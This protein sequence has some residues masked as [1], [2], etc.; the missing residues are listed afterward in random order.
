MVQKAKA[1]GRALA[2]EE[3][4]SIRTSKS[5]SSKRYQKSL[6][7]LRNSRNKILNVS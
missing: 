4:D 1:R 3:W 7:K 2:K 6:T 5:R